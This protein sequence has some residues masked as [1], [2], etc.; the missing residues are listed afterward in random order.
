MLSIK[1]TM[2]LMTMLLAPTNCLSSISSFLTTTTSCTGITTGM[3][4]QVL[5]RCVTTSVLHVC[6]NR[7]V[8]TGVLQVFIII[9]ITRKTALTVRLQS[10]L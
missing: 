1:I 7:C 3:L 4:Q 2:P 6:Y 8:T 10:N 5:Y 9:R